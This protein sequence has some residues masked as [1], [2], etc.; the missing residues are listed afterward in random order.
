MDGDDA[1]TERP[2]PPRPKSTDDRPVLP[3]VSRDETAEG[4]GERP[5]QRD[6]E[7]YQRERPPHHE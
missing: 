1:R 4:W 6:D 7:W 5:D 2:V 3:G